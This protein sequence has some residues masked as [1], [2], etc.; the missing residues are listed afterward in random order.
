MKLE[1]LAKQAALEAA[2]AH[3]L[4]RERRN[5]ARAARHLADLAAALP[6]GPP[7]P[8]QAPPAPPKDS[9]FLQQLAA[10]LTGKDEDGA[11]ILLKAEFWR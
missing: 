11:L 3:S 8:P 6:H 4:R 2:V 7:P 10:A 5:P 1:D 9:P